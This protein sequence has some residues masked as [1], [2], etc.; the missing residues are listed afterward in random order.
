M[1]GRDALGMELHA[2]DRQVAV[3]DPHDEP[4]IGLGRHLEVARAGVAGDDER[5]VARRRE[6]SR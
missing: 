6:M 4:V 3:G 1:L 5:V 2:V